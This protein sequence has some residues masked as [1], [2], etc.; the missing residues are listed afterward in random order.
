[1]VS[2]GPYGRT[3]RRS[4]GEGPTE[5]GEKGRPL[6]RLPSLDDFRDQIEPSLDGRRVPLVELAPVGLGHDIVAQPLRPIQRVGHRLDAVGRHGRELA[7][8]VDDVRK[9]LRD[10][11]DLV[12]V[13]LEPRQLAELVDIL[14]SERH[15]VIRVTNI[16][17]DYTLR[18]PI[19]PPVAKVAARFSPAA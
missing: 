6:A 3:E 15:R 8:H 14:L 7:H 1:S 5:R 16:S 2:D 12:G 10:V 11:A 19:V 9:L 17:L 4:R 18:L 13:D